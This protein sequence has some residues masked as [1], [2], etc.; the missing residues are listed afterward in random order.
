M[1][2]LLKTSLIAAA[3]FATNFSN[4]AAAC[5]P[6]IPEKYLSFFSTQFI[7]YAPLKESLRVRPFFDDD[8]AELPAGLRDENN[9]IRNPYWANPRDRANL[10]E[11]KAYLETNKIAWLSDSPGSYH[12]LSYLIYKFDLTAFGNIHQHR[13]DAQ[14]NPLSEYT[15][16]TFQRLQVSQY[17]HDFLYHTDWL[18]TSISEQSELVEYLQFA[19]ACEVRAFDQ[20]NDDGWGERDPFDPAAMRELIEEGKARYA[21]CSSE[22][23]K[24][25]YAYQVVR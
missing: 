3:M 25:R 12:A 15:R 1:T 7:G 18:F 4:T 20:S 16:K 2:S 21:A 11:W 8:A 24:M 6:E 5:G 17:E 22:W 19:K 14:N 9:I 13:N 10:L 23:L